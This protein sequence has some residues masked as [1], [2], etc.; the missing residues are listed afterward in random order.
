MRAAAAVSNA[1]RVRRIAVTAM[2]SEGDVRPFVALAAGLRRGGH[3]AWLVAAERYRARSEGASVPFR[4]TGQRWDEA[5]YRAAMSAVLAERSPMKQIKQFVELGANEL[6]TAAPGVVEATSDADLIVHHAGDVNAFAA[7]IAHG[8]PRMT[9]ALA[10]GLLPGGFAAWIAR[11]MIPSMT[12]AVFGRVLEAAGV[13]RQK[14]VVLETAESPLLNMVAISR[15]V[16]PPRRAWRGRFEPTGYWFLDE[17]QHEPDARLRAFVEGGEPPIVI[18]FGSMTE[19]DARVR[20][21]A[22]GIVEAVRASGRRA[23]VQAAEGLGDAD[24][25]ETIHVTGYVPHDWLFPRS[26]GV[27]H[28]GG[29]GTSAAALR[30]RVPQAIVSVFGDQPAWGKL[31]HQRGVAA[32]PMSMASFTASALSDR[33]RAMDDAMRERATALGDLVAGEDGVA[34]ACALIEERIPRA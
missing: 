24:V 12:D 28:H 27:V 29:A 33:I 13:P 32:A 8:T 4:P 10:P 14:R 23:V 2:G 31:L 30:A 1:P 18:G 6:A 9:G 22:A 34:R 11:L 7:S 25:P 5:A 3:D 21:I 17:P 16:V 19:L 20:G 15:H 26:A